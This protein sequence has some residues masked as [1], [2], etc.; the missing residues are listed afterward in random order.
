MPSAN[1]TNVQMRDH[2]LRKCRLGLHFRVAARMALRRASGAT[3]VTGKRKMALRGNPL[4]R[5]GCPSAEGGCVEDALAKPMQCS[6]V[7]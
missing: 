4:T 5:I 3:G 6:P 2:G 1:R 7:Q